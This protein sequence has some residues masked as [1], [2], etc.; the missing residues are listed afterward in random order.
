MVL[1]K[2]R[3]K[4]IVFYHFFCDKTPLEDEK[5]RHFKY[6]IDFGVQYTPYDHEGLNFI[7]I[8][9]VSPFMHNYKT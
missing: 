8:G 4:K 3:F 1:G 2:T 6:K 7:K 5:V 9:E